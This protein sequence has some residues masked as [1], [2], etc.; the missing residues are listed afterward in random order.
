MSFRQHILDHVALSVSDL[1]VS[2]AFYEAALAPLGYKLLWQS[3]QSLA[4]GV[5]GSDDFG[6]NLGARA[7]HHAHV[8]FIAL[9]QAAVRAFYAA[10]LAAGGRDNGAPGFHR[11]YH[12]TYYAAFVLDPDD[13]NIEAVFHGR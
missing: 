6:L 1:S 10:A 8:A 12:P 7:A 2:R 4:F 9:D 5:P 3:A 13:N 11:E